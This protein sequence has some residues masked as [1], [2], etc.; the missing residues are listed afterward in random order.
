VLKTDQIEIR[1]LAREFAAK[2]I[3]PHSSHWDEKR[4]L[5]SDIFVKIGELGFMGMC[6]PERYGGLD[7]DIE[8]YLMVLEELA[9]GDASLALSVAIH[10]GPVATLLLNYGSEEQKDKYLPSLASGSVIGAFALSEVSAG[11]D[12]ASIQ[13]QA[14]S[15]DDGNWILNGTKRWVTNGDRAGLIMVFAV[16]DGETNGNTY[17]SQGGK[18][19]GVFLVERDSKGYCVT[20]RD[21]TMG[22]RASQTVSLDLQDIKLTPDCV[23]GDPNRGLHYA[24]QALNVGRLGVAA[25]SVGIA[26]EAFEHATQY[27]LERHQFGQAIADFGAIQ[28]KLA[29]MASRIASS[30]SL[31]RTAAYTMES[32]SNGIDRSAYTVP[33]MS[34]MAKLTA[35][36]NAVWVT[37]EAVQIFGGYGYM[38]DYPVEKLMRDAKGTEIYEG[39]NEIM[40]V[41]VAREILKH[42]SGDL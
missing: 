3:R 25:Q 15:R 21:V 4:D 17:K 39:T 19:V 7:L 35:S 8:T 9:W 11:S 20:G 10:N 31:I 1:A 6:I 36:E 30:R 32:D 42:A 40:R 24:F 34:A 18:S 14:I 2:E 28:F 16:T 33:A 29:D 12:P 37:D 13:T 5:D 41:V 27:A 23:L 22:L 26:Q 38:R